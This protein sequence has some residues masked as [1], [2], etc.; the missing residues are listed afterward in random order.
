MLISAHSAHPPRR[1]PARR[2]APEVH[3]RPGLVG[4]SCSPLVLQLVLRRE[5]WEVRTSR[6]IDGGCG[7]TSSRTSCGRSSASTPMPTASLSPTASG[8]PSLPRGPTPLADLTRALARDLI[9]AG[10]EIHDCAGKAPGAGVCLT[11][12]S[13]AQGVIVTWTQPTPPRPPSGLR[14][15]RRGLRSGDSPPRHRAED[16]RRRRR[17]RRARRRGLAGPLPRAGDSISRK[18]NA[19]SASRH[20]TRCRRLRPAGAPVSPDAADPPTVRSELARRSSR[21]WWAQA[22]ARPRDIAQQRST[23]G[24]DECQSRRSE[25]VPRHKRR[26]AHHPDHALQARRRP[27]E[28]QPGACPARKWRRPPA[29]LGR[30]GR[31]R[32]RGRAEGNNAARPGRRTCGLSSSIAYKH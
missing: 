32:G 18:E 1:R 12:G 4:H 21:R 13:N 17:R 22:A 3:R 29:A 8:C 30:W 31:S 2:P 6:C 5:R 25:A 11:P 20:R 16:G 14:P 7:R 28:A 23:G 26:S 27:S 19:S 24:N 10:F 9:A 15:S